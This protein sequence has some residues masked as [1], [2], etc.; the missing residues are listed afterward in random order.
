MAVVEKLREPTPPKF[1][2][3]APPE[4]PMLFEVFGTPPLFETTV[5]VADLEPLLVGVKVNV[6]R[7]VCPGCSPAPPMGQV[8]VC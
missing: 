8:L 7:Q 3:A 4:I 2:C 6:T 5:N 1:G